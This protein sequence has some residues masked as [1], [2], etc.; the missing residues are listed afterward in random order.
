MPSLSL[1][2]TIL[3]ADYGHLFAAGLI[4]YQIKT[5]GLHWKRHALLAACMALQIA[6]GNLE[7]VAMTTAF[8]ALFYLFVGDRLGWIAVRPIV[9]LGTISYAR[10]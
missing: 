5:V 6:E 2:K 8:F 10:I 1:A 7:A 3:I 9:Y 4:F